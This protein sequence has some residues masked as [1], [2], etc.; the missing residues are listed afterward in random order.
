[1]PAR[2][3][4]ALKS[5]TNIVTVVLNQEESDEFMID[6]HSKQ[7]IRI[8]KSAII[9]N[10]NVN[11]LSQPGNSGELTYEMKIYKW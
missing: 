1:M 3:T 9:G 10:C 11:T 8:R 2:S 6:K 4:L 7:S 5:T